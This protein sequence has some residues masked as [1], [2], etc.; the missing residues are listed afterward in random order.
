MIS[1][2]VQ[3]G[4]VNKG[5]IGWIEEEDSLFVFYVLFGDVDKFF[6]FEC[7]SFEWFNFGINQ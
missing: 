7:S 4:W 1:Y 3:F 5:E 2:I 6:V